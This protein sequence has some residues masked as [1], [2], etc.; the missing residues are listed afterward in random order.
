VGKWLKFDIFAARM[1]SFRLVCAM[2]N[3][4]CAVTYSPCTDL[5]LIAQRLVGVAVV[6]V[7]CYRMHS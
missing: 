6:V 1:A 3:V 4:P 5:E 7:Y 2:R